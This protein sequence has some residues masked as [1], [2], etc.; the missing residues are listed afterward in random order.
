MLESIAT[1][2]VMLAVPA[3]LVAEFFVLPAEYFGKSVSEDASWPRL[4]WRSM[5]AVIL[6]KLASGFLELFGPRDPTI[7]MSSLI[8]FAIIAMSVGYAYHAA[9]EVVPLL[10]GLRELRG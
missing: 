3:G 1:V 6:F 5:A 10:R 7:A 2:F 9:R 4:V 8:Y